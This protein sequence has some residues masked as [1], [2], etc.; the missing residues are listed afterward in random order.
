[1]KLPPDDNQEDIDRITAELG[2]HEG[3]VGETRR[4]EALTQK[5]ENEIPSEGAKTRR[6][7]K[8]KQH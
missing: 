8:P 5:R 3:D 7:A 4:L 2:R 6:R 1:M